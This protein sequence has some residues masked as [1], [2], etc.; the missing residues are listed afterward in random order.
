V[1]KLAH[2][3]GQ[4]LSQHIADVWL[5]M[6]AEAYAPKT[7]EDYREKWGP[8]YVALGRELGR[9]PLLAD[10]QLDWARR[11]IIARLR[12]DGERRPL[13]PVSAAAHVR[14]L[15]ALSTRLFNEGKTG[16][17]RL[18]ALREPRGDGEEKTALTADEVGAL[19]DAASGIALG[20][21]RNGA[22]IAVLVDV[23]PRISEI[24]AAN[25]EDIEW[26]KGWI[27]IVHPAKRGPRRNIPLGRE[28]RRLLQAYVGKRRRGPLFLA[29]QETRMTAAAARQV[30]ARLSARLE[31]A[32]VSPHDLRHTAATF[33][34]R[35]VTDDAVAAKV[36]GWAPA[37]DYTKARY[38][39][40]S[41]EDVAAIHQKGSLLDHVFGLR[42]RRAAGRLVS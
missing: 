31:I 37:G 26:A 13:A 2:Y 1:D 36:F 10:L 22:L 27:T 42:R 40:L 6:D 3:D 15:K 33:Y 28:T 24:L 35:L 29:G 38:T 14:V 4:P 34:S 11:Y 12:P 9:R 30:L 19:L 23:G 17:N 5:A 18:A 32:R 7:I 8:F 41:W 16:T 20:A 25:V 21:R 39:H